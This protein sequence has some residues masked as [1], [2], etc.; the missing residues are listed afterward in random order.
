MKIQRLLMVLLVV[1][2]L[3]ALPATL[4][5]AQ[6]E[7]NGIAMTVKAGFDG[8]YKDAMWIPVRVTLSN[9][10]PD[11]A[12]G[13]VRIA[14]PRYDGSMVE[15]NRPVEMPSGSRKEV[16]L[17]I[18]VEGYVSKV[19]V[20]YTSGSDTLANQSARI[21]QLSA[22]DLLYG[23]VATSASAFNVLTQIDP[24]NGQ[25]RVAQM[26]LQ[27]LPPASIAW[28]ALDA[29]I[30]SDVDTG[31]LTA[32]QQDALRTWVSGGGRL[33]V[34]GG[35]N[36]QK[37]AAGLG[38]LLPL[39]PSGSQTVEGLDALAAYAY[40]DVP[41]PSLLVTTGQLQPGA[42]AL[43]SAG[44]A[45][46]VVERV[47]GYGRVDFMTFDPSLDPI[48][49]WSGTEGVFRSILSV[50]NERPG[51]AGSYRNWYNAGEAVNAI[52]GIGLPHVLQVC[53]FLAGYIAVIGPLNYLI[54]RRFKRR[55]LAWVTI[56][57][58]VILFA[59]ITYVASFGLRGTRATLH[60]LTVA[61]VWENSDRAQVETL[62]GIFSP[63]RSEYDLQ[64]DGDLLLRPLPSDTYYGTV[65]T[66]LDGAFIE[67]ADTA[68]IR[69]VRVDVGAIKP[70]VAQ[71][72]IPAP[73]FVSALEYGVTGANPSLKGTITNLSTVALHDAVVLAFSGFQQVGEV[74]PGQ[75]IGVDIPLTS[76]RATWTV[77]SSTQ[78]LSS[79]VP[80]TS[81]YPS[82]YYSGYDST[83]ENILGTT[84]YYDDR[85]TY[86]RYSLLT[87]LFD[88]YSSGGRG[89]GTY[90]VG[91]A[92]ESPVN[93]SLA[94]GD[95][96]TA[97]QTL[98]LVRLQPR[99]VLG[100]GAISIPPGLMTWETLDPG[101]GGGG[102]PYDSY[103]SQGYFTLRYRPFAGLDFT[104]IDSLTMH[105]D[106]YGA[107]GSSQL[108]I[109]LWNQETG[110]W[111]EMKG[112]KW[113]DTEIE[114]PER[115][116][117]GDGHIDVRVDNSSFQNS[118][119]I[120]NVDFTLVVER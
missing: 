33:I 58:I 112:V 52:P 8:Y 92:N 80:A 45:P 1:G 10:G 82:G 34:A 2:M 116:V 7:S 72:Q 81:L 18:A 22:S 70:F 68:S 78:I 76:N 94:G 21:T 113:G 56:P 27:D 64:V 41:G 106:S 48:K 24:I 104:N 23:V 50:S 99:M 42:I 100:N 91:W 86:R 115:F 55:E 40:D 46:L 38:D 53:V 85:E 44:N 110:E 3:L 30:I 120:E 28:R 114:S 26:V 73:E 20:T 6:T 9:D 19:G 119:S 49:G 74:A 31:E 66:S 54:L 36:W 16:T 35:P 97:D 62:V 118:V 79:G 15:Y 109:S 101:N 93:V 17:Y 13:V 12:G 103:L 96:N 87:W 51:W 47:L 32:E 111:V 61:Q 95:F 5:N 43:V 65:D 108:D 107:K 89:S 71:G 11:V 4:A 14:A 117:G 69:H 63:R 88:P 102:S 67:Q 98:F 59:S 77:Q 90:L 84:S 39:A 75:T 29:L 60:R 105:L 25:G 83:I 57:A 37:V